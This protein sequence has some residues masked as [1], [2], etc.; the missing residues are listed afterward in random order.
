MQGD[1]TRSMV[2]GVGASQ[3]KREVPSDGRAL[4][5]VDL[6]AQSCRV[7]LLRWQDGVPAWQLIHR[8]ENGPLSSARGLIWPLEAIARAVEEGLRLCAEAAPEGI[9][10][11]GID[12]WAVDYVRLQP[13]GSWLQEP[14]CYRDERNRIAE[15]ELLQRISPQRLFELTGIQPLNLN[16]LFQLFADHAGKIPPAMPWVN[17]PEALLA[18]LGAEPVAEYT[19]ATHTQLL[20]L[21]SRQ[22]CEEIFA[23][24]GL[25][26]EAAPK[27]VPPGTVVGTLKGPLAEIP[28]LKGAKLIAPACHDT[29]S[30]VAGSPFSGED[31]VFICSG[32]WSLVG[33]VVEQPV[34]SEE[35][36]LAGFTNVGGLDS[37]YCF[38]R[39]VNGM[40]LLSQCLEDWRQ[41]GKTWD[42]AELV[43]ICETLPTPSVCLDVDAPE[44]SQPGPM[45]VRLNRQLMEK[46]APALPTDPE[47]APEVA[48]VLFHSLAEKYARVLADVRRFT[49]RQ[50]RQVC[51]VGGGSRNQYLNRLTEQKTGIKIVTGPAESSTVGNFA[52]Q[53][54]CLEGARGS[55]GVRIEAVAHWATLLNGA[56]APQL[57]TVA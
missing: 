43:A 33:M 7:S 53:F 45:L 36:R 8:V 10:A 50:F 16:T 12:G 47:A 55:F 46:G 52:I 17:L 26:L 56:M 27:V 13:N 14:F 42:V 41:A 24:A 38:L 20:G 23:V 2:L 37:R 44:L 35:A 54:A 32:T 31:W 6:G 22:W 15:A 39:N 49:G 9:A 57:D 40:W 48:N 18:R 1:K 4:V 51:V 3:D 11:I 19:N 30:A 28:Q 21:H 34:V 25:S 29:A 5:A